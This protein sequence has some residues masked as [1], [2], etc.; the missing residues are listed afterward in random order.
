MEK[1]LKKSLLFMILASFCFAITG[2]LA[3][4]LKD[5][6]SSV[7]LVLFRNI[8]GLPFLL[9]FIKSTPIIQVGGKPFLLFFRG[10][11][12]TI[13]LCF[14][15]YGVTTI[16]LP[17]SITYQQSYP[18]FLALVSVL[19]LG[20]KINRNGWI[21]IFMGFIG[22]CLIFVPK[23]MSTF[24][25]AK[26]HIIGMSNL[27]LTGIAYL[28]I[29]GL[30]AYYENKI[31]VLSFMLCGILFPLLFLGIGEVYQNQNLDFLLGKFMLPKI[32]H[33]YLILP[34][35]LVALTGQVFL[36]KA[37]SHKNTGLIG[38]MG[39]SNVVFSIFFGVLIGDPLPDFL[40]MIGI[41]VIIVSGVILSLSK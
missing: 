35:G 40:S 27:I 9:Y 28:S 24:M 34:L 37:F 2:A 19:F 25:E 16:G 23:M 20:Q 4:L 41:F 29:R 26:S 3:R 18:I 36:T 22:V 33:L 6:Y 8:I 30:S 13:A 10:F 38:A 39:Y 31:I 14:F 15:F 1:E 5:D 32:Q 7:Q 11:I 21:A 12:G 17:E